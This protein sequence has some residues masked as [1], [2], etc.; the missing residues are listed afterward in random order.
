M[1]ANDRQRQPNETLVAYEDRL[2]ALHVA[3][4]A[5][6]PKHARDMTVGERT[7]ALL[8]LTRDQPFVSNSPADYGVKPETR[9]AFLMTSE[10]QKTVLHRM[11]I[12]L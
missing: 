1:L 7:E 4:N 6:A 10:E 11:G 2:R 12:Y 9:S 3:E 8:E 5:P